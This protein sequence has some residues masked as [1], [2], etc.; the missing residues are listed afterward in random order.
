MNAAE[1]AAGPVGVVLAGGAGRRI[2]GAKASTMLAGRPLIAYPLAALRAV[3]A[4][5][6]VVAKRDSDL[7]PVGYV[8]EIWREPDEPQHPLV[9]IIEA[10]RRADGRSVV[11]LACDLPL[12]TPDVIRALLA[13]PPAAAVLARAGDDVQPL[14]A[15]FAPGTLTSFAAA[16]PRDRLQDVVRSLAPAYVDVDPDVLLNV[17][18]PAGLALA[19]ARLG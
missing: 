3:L 2:G 12:V 6:A 17:N 5:V 13:A 9:G 10:L 4:P 19:E 7:P 8:V 1:P 11:V 14:C 15:R 18:D 16:G